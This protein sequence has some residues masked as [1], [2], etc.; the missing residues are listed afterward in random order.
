MEIHSVKYRCIP[1]YQP[2]YVKT[3]TIHTKE[4]LSVI[5]EQKKQNEIQN[6]HKKWGSQTIEPTQAPVEYV[7]RSA[8]FVNSIRDKFQREREEKIEILKKESQRSADFKH[9]RSQSCSKHYPIERRVIGTQSPKYHR[10]ATFGTLDIS[11]NPNLG[12]TPNNS[13][14]VYDTKKEKNKVSAFAQAL[15]NAAWRKKGV[16]ASNW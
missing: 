10:R 9:V 14:T 15:E 4:A 2:E 16:T 3:A 6:L 5:A 13:P 11:R 7:P 8:E 1:V 12:K